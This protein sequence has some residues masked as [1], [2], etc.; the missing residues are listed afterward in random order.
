MMTRIDRGDNAKTADQ[1]RD[2][3]R[4]SSEG[5]DEEQQPIKWKNFLSDDER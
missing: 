2:T 5:S 3:G 4:E 1:N